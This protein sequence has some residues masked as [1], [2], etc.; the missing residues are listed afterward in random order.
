MMPR[1]K[2]ESFRRFDSIIMASDITTIHTA[3][4]DNMQELV[5]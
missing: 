2:Y 5:S 1:I 3:L 4:K